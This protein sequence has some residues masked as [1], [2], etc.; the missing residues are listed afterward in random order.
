MRFRGA[1]TAL[2]TPFT[3]DDTIDERALERLLD[4]QLSGGI[5][6]VVLS[7]TTGESPTL[8]T[9]E[10]TRL[11][12]VAR[13]RVGTRVP[14]ILGTGTNSTRATIEE[15]KAAKAAG[16]DAVLVVCPYYNKPN[17]EGLYQHFMAIRDAADLPIIAYNVP[18]RTVTDLMPDTIARLVRAGAIAAVK[19]ATGNMQRTAETLALVGD[20]PF[21]YLS[22]DDFSF[23][24]FVAAG[25]HGVIS[26]VSNLLPRDTTTIVR[27]TRAGNLA[28]AQ[29]LNQRVVTFT[30]ALFAD[31]SPIPLKAAM[32]IVG[33]CSPRLRLPLV[34]ASDEVVKKL[35]AAFVAFEASEAP[36]K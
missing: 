17:Q 1:M 7:G 15:T 2:V 31:T 24:P 21:D 9:V 35:K 33:L 12:E 36:S 27:E 18:S 26:V 34:D 14:L 8:T 32:G 3:D 11:L 16:A 13:A 29:R 23:M 19:D 4:F 6:G 30:K 10:R 5:E 20:Q 28:A 22:G 25:G